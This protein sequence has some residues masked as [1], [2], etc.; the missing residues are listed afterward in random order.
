M[1]ISPTEPKMLRDLGKVDSLPE[2]YGCDFLYAS[3]VGFVGVQRK[4]VGDL[5]A[6][7]Q[8]GRLQEQLAK[9]KQLDRGVVL[10]EGDAK[11]TNEGMLVGNSYWTMSQHLG[12]IWSIQLDSFWIASTNSLTHTAKWLELFGRWLALNKTEGLARRQKVKASWGTRDN[13]DWAIGVLSQIDGISLEFAGRI[14]DKFGM[15][16]KWTISAEELMTVE[17]IGVKRAEKMMGCLSASPLTNM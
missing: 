8:T 15:P 4:E 1:L 9:M 17:G 10:I 6:S 11:W 16:I 2:K 13:R 14:Y 7:V 5:V 3:K 12:V